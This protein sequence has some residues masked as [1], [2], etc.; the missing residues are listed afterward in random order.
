MGTP[1]NRVINS[2]QKWSWYG[3]CRCFVM[4]TRATCRAHSSQIK[5]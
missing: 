2:N 5:L 3:N 1:G 4:W